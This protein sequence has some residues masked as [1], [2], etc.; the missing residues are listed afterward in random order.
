M[1][2]IFSDTSVRL[3]SGKD[4]V[5]SLA[6]KIRSDKNTGLLPIE[7]ENKPVFTN[8]SELLENEK[9]DSALLFKKPKLFSKKI[10][11]DKSLIKGEQVRIELL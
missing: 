10:K 2:E 6:S 7:E 8:T 4:I 3:R 1:S 11:K 5:K 9:E